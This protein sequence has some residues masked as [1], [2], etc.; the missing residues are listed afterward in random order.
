MD[1]R[2]SV[3]NLNDTVLIITNSDLIIINISNTFI[4]ENLTL[5][6]GSSIL[7]LLQEHLEDELYKNICRSV[8]QHQSFDFQVKTY[9]FEAHPFTFHD[10][11]LYSI[12]GSFQNTYHR[13]PSEMEDYIINIIRYSPGFI[14]LKDSEFRYIMCNENFARV[15]GLSSPN[16]II[17]KTDYDLVWKDTQADLFRQGDIAALK[18]IK[19]I[20]FEEPQLQVDGETRIVLANKVPLLDKNDKIVGILGNYLD[21]TERKNLEIELRTAKEKAEAAYYIMTE[22]ISNMGHDLTTP[23]SDVGSIAQMLNFYADEYLELKELINSLVLRWEA[24]EKVRERIINSTSLSN[25]KVRN[26]IF[27]IAQELLILEAELRPTI[28]SKNLKLVIQPPKPKKEDRIETDRKKFHDILF[29]LM[30]NA[31]NFTEEGQVTITVLKQDNKF[32]IHVKDTGI[33]IP[34]DKFDYIFE[35]YTK[36]SRSNKYGTI[37]KGVGAGLYLARIRGNILNATISVAS[38]VN[39]GST[40]T[41]SIPSHPVERR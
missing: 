21:I 26:E 28:G 4:N 39:K 24:C 30:S 3:G 23:I 33:G 11:N 40:F 32:H 9:I 8:K 22:F 12:I 38:E 6:Q 16:E 1:Q 41:L 19:K 14:Y 36:L 15:A 20:N 2:K 31:I 25:L 29:D 17:G 5:S 7:S 35:Q 27:S 37:F 13:S 10:N 34:A 18:G